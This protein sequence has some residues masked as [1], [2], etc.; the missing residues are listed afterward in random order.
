MSHDDDDDDDDDGGDSGGG[1]GTL[2]YLWLLALRDLL[3]LV[4][5]LH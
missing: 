4:L 1:G 2:S 5:R 3:E